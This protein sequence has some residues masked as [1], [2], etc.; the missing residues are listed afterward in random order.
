MVLDVVNIGTL[1]DS[2]EQQRTI[3]EAQMA[4]PE[5]GGQSHTHAPTDDAVVCQHVV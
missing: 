5:A 4:V 1:G 2:T 3:G